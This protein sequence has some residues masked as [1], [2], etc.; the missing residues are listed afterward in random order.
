MVT[1]L[2]G[3]PGRKCGGKAGYET[4][5]KGSKVI[6]NIT[7]FLREIHDLRDSGRIQLGDELWTILFGDLD[8]WKRPPEV[9][10]E[11]VV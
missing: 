2:G 1:E 6:S 4:F 9:A 5:W 8:K 3:N 10:K 7:G 11:S